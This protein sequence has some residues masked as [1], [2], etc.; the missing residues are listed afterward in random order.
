MK[1]SLLKTHHL[2]TISQ[3]T[4]T[5]LKITLDLEFNFD[6]ETY[7]LRSRFVPEVKIISTSISTHIM[8][9]ETFGIPTRKKTLV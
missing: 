8:S 1:T 2:R 3:E 7:D 4:E 9:S 5:V 6:F